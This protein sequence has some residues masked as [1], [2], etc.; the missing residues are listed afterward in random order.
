MKLKKS[1]ILVRKT[2]EEFHNAFTPLYDRLPNK[3]WREVW[4][5]LGSK[6]TNRVYNDVYRPVEPVICDQCNY[7]QQI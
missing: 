3:I 5:A 6:V 7:I 2:G 1:D 4:V